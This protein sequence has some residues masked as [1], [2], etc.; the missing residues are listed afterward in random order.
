MEFVININ[1]NEIEKIINFVSDKTAIHKER[2]IVNEINVINDYNCKL[3]N[4]KIYLFVFPNN[5]FNEFIFFINSEKHYLNCNG[6]MFMNDDCNIKVIKNAN[7]ADIN[8]ELHKLDKIKLYMFTDLIKENMPE[9]KEIS[10]KL[11]NGIL[12]FENKDLITNDLCDE[13][14]NYINKLDN[15]NIEKWGINTNVNCKFVNINNIDDVDIKRKFDSK[16]YKII[17]WVINQLKSDYDITCSGDSGY[18][19][20]KIYGPT[21]LHKDGININP[22][23]N[24]YLPIKKIRNMSLIICLNDNYEGGE[25]YFP[26]QDFK[27]KLKKGQIIAFPPYWT[28][29]HMV[30]ELINKTYR[31]TINTWLF[32]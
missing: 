6:L 9:N 22:I 20:R 12:I 24:R 2:L 19:L 27:I 32:E 15:A 4:K 16:L 11:S 26:C 7:D 31:Y 5:K 30:S 3:D 18:C 29:P 1:E 14:I 25:F 8:E 13:L 28:H 23:D 17:S 21:R 10:Y